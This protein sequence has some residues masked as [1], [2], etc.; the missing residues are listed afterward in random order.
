VHYSLKIRSGQ[1]VRIAGPAFAAPLLVAAYRETLAAGAH[2]FT[3]VTID[4]LDEI[5]FKHGSDEQLRYVSPLVEMEYERIDASLG[6]WGDWNTR[7]LSGVD[8][9]RQALRRE[10]TR[11]LSQRFMERAA[12]GEVRWVGTQYP[13][14]ADAQE[15]EMSLAEYEDFVFGAGLLDRPDPV[16]AWERVREDQQRV[17]DLLKGRQTLY[18]RG[19]DIDLT[20]GVGG[21]TWI[22]AAGEYNFP[23]G[24]VFTGPVEAAT[25]GRVKFSFPAIYSGREVR[26]VELIFSDGRVVSATAEKGEEFLRTMLGLDEGAGRIGEFAFGLNYGITRFTRNILFD[27]KIGGT[28]H[29]ALGAGYPETGSRNQSG[30]H[31]DMICDLRDDAEVAADGETIYRNGTFLT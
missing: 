11:T 25:S 20:V 13:S 14:Y 6:V 15:A 8:P 2:P 7:S 9:K 1:L 24:E 18:L 29:M 22:N 30:L 16:A 23:D 21:R 26:N 17:I 10:A 5:F 4:G 19:K 3:R 12:R 27:E 31:W 28:I